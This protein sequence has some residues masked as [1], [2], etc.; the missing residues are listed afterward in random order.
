MLKRS[1]VMSLI[2]S[3]ENQ[4]TELRMM[5]LFCAHGITGWR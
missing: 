4:D 5:A 2:R 3:S 1:A